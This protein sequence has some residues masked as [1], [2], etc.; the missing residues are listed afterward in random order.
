MEMNP[1]E[2]I[3]AALCHEPVGRVPIDFCGH[4]DTVIHR[5]AYERLLSKR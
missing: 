4:N 3:L 5:Q 1:R 2:R